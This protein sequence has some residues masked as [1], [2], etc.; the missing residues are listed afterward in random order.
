MLRDAQNKADL[1]ITDAQIKAD[2]L[3]EKANRE[4]ELRHSEAELIKHEVSEFKL[5]VMRMYRTHLELINALPSESDTPIAETEDVSVSADETPEP[6]AETQQENV[7]E[8][9]PLPLFESNIAVQPLDEWWEASAP[10]PLEPKE[11]TVQT[12]QD[13]VVKE[14]ETEDKAEI[15]VENETKDQ[16]A[17]TVMLN[18]RYNQ[19]TGEY[20]PIDAPKSFDLSD[21]SAEQNEKGSIK[22]GAA[23]DISTDSFKDGTSRHGSKKR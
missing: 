11:E 7:V 5:K 14:P 17:A 21:F 15:L 2:N 23:Y 20:E 9:A 13:K 1:T 4:I 8:E 12:S 6:K 22:F 16:V 18:L 19:K 3:T 10:L